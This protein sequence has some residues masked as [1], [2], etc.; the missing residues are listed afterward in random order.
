MHTVRV[1]DSV[2]YTQYVRY[3]SQSGHCDIHVSSENE[4][5]ILP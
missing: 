1:H 2:E 3:L 5:H 4:E